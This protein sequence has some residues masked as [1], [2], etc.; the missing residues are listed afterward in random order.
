MTTN[1]SRR[2]RRAAA[3]LAG[4]I[5]TV[6]MLGL[7]APTAMADTLDPGAEESISDEQTS[8]SSPTTDAVEAS[9]GEQGADNGAVGPP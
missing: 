5:V 1:I 3:F 9:G 6:G 2:P 4:P 7:V 8:E